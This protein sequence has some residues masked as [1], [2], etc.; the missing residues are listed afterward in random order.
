M[1]ILVTGAGGFIGRT[2]VRKARARGWRVTGVSRRSGEETD[3]VADL[4][5]PQ[6]DLPRADAVVH[7]AG[8][9]IGCGAKQLAAL[10][11]VMARNLIAWGRR[12]QVRRWVF[13][14]AAEVY[15]PVDG[16]ADE[17]W[18][19]RPVLPYGRVKL[20]IEN[21]FQT[22]GLPE[23]AICRLGE[24]YGPGGRIMREIGGRLKKGFCPWP[25]DGEVK[26]SFLHVE[27]AAE[28]LLLACERARPGCHI[29][30]AG[31]GTPATW[32]LFL[33]SITALAGGRPAFYLPLWLARV[34]A[35]CASMTDRLLGRPAAVTRHVLRLLTTPKVLSSR[36][37]SNDLGFKPE[38]REFTLGLKGA[39]DGL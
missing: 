38:Y 33:D 34:Y 18:P 5:D 25:G 6:A 23:I 14:S 27:D 17:N 29:Y 39:L 36:R 22:S 37:L 26:L 35:G 30:N 13:A 19:C 9:Y 28:A 10:D 8:G 32:R 20:E 7:L 4:R 21:M 11:T 1:Q 24:V 16:V 15:G 2:V 12:Q 31:D 3:W